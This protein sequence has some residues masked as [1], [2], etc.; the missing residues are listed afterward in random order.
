MKKIV[1]FI[2][3]EFLYAGHLQAIG[4]SGIV[5]AST[6][7]NYHRFSSL[8]L[9]IVTYLIFQF[10]YYVDRYRNIESD[11]STNLNRSL[12]FESYAKFLP[13]ILAAYFLLIVVI[14]LVFSNILTLLIS[15][16]IVFMG[17][18]YPIYFKEVTRY[19]Y[20]FKNIYVSLVFGIMVFYPLFY[21]GYSLSFSNVLTFLF[22]FTFIEGLI[23]QA[24]LD[25]K[26][27]KTDRKSHLLTLP[28]LFGKYRLIYLVNV[29]S[30]FYGATFLLISLFLFNNLSLSS[31]VL[32]SM[33]LNIYAA[34][35]IKDSKIFGYLLS[36]GK[37]DSWFVP[38]IL[39]M[40]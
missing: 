29:V 31:L 24:L 16:F 30:L 28:A 22:F 1:S 17:V 6:Y 3:T 2:K 15:L 37:Y 19:V 11:K 32:I 7:V 35:D 38:I 27:V 12:H 26:D 13:F 5:F 34:K 36:A 8:D 39:L 23:S 14:C 18:L 33:I 21:Y 20:A 9:L 10:I 25:V 4:S 40:H